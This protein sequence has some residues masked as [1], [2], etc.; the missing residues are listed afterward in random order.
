MVW[1]NKELGKVIQWGANLSCHCK[2]HP[3]CREP[4]S[5]HWRTDQVLEKWLLDAAKQS[6]EIRLSREQLQVKIA[7]LHANARAPR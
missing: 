6:G 3:R 1:K 5:T 7:A 2:L 4:V